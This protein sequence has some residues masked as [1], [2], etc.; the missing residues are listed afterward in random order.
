MGKKNK[1][2]KFLTELATLKKKMS[3]LEASFKK[4]MK[5]KIAKSKKTPVVAVKKKAIKKTVVKKAG[6]GLK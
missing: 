1:T 2:A 4:A 6:L 3:K 5:D